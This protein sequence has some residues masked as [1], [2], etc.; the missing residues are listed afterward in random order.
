MTNTTLPTPLARVRDDDPAAG[1]TAADVHRVLAGRR[2]VAVIWD[3]ED[4]QML[5]P[6]LT[7][8]DAWRVLEFVVRHHD[9]GIGIHWEVL[10]HV[11]EALFPDAAA[12][13]PGG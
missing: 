5:R 8:A 3:V 4:V 6:D 10:E 11:A 7:D 13:T 9:A 2:Q 1:L 12:D